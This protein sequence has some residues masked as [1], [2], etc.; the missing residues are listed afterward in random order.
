MA[1]SIKAQGPMDAYMKKESKPPPPPHSSDGAA[2]SDGAVIASIPSSKYTS[3]LWEAAVGNIRQKLPSDID[4]SNPRAIL[5]QVVVEADERKEESKAKEHKVKLPGKSG[6]EVKLREV[7]GSILSCAKRFRDVGDIAM[8]ASPPQAALP[9]AIVRLCLTA[10]FNEHEFYGVMIQGLEMVSSI[11]THYIVIERLFVGEISDHAQ[12]VR[13]SLLALYAALLDFLVEALKYFPSP[14]KEEEKTIKHYFRKGA[15]KA[16]RTFMSLDV[17]S[18]NEIK[19]LLNQVSKSKD[20][21]DSDSN[22]AYATM[23]LHAIS[24]SERFQDHISKQLDAMQLTEDEKDRRLDMLLKEFERPLGSIES[25]VSEIYESMEQSREEAYVREVLDWLSPATFDNKRRAY[26]QSLL[27]TRSNLPASGAWLLQDSNFVQWHSSNRSSIAWLRGISGT[28]KTTLTAI[29]VDHLQSLQ[30]RNAN[31]ERLAFF[32]TSPA[33][34]F[35]SRAD[36]DDIIRNLTRQLSHIAG[37]P[38]LEV[39]IKQRFE[40]VAS[41]TDQPL[42][43][44]TDEC[45]NMIFDLSISY[46]IYIVIDGLDD[47]TEGDSNSQ[48]RSSTNEFIQ[49]LRQVLQRSSSPIKLFFSTLSDSSAEKRLRNNFGNDYDNQQNGLYGLHVIEVNAD[50]NHR[51]MENFINDKVTKRI[52]S[53]ELLEGEVDS[54]LK[55]KITERLLQRSN[56]KFSFVSVLIDRI[57]DESMSESMVLEEIENSP[58]ITD[59]YERSVDEIRNSGKPRVQVTAKAT[60]RWLL[61]LQEQ[62]YTQEFLEAINIEVR[63][64]YVSIKRTYFQV[65]SDSMYLIY[66]QSAM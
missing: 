8:Q 22:H 37:N 30:S 19:R 16:R 51:D 23:N 33:K 52:R 42:K 13:N 56:G 36:P 66:T 47:T 58:G 45:I 65:A 40:Q 49:A 57:C 11:V 14:R 12:A 2:V 61:C 5:Q 20:D 26:H 64:N 7:Y 59:I 35:D 55:T 43:P 27:N 3:S 41:A 54:T 6:K 21:V 24:K 1:A 17:T 60:L 18:Q 46:S 62:L 25:K 39:A 63:A 29:V 50:N 10:A 31:A 15:D 53:N 9:W 28:G 44:T 38:E 32:Y 48:V 34:D 4:R